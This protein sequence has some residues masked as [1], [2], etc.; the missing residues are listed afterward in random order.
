MPPDARSRPGTAGTALDDPSRSPILVTGATGFVM[1]NL[2]RHL[3]AHGHTVV[4]ADVVPPD[5]PMTRFVTGLRGAVAFERLDVT[6]RGGVSALVARVRPER[7]VH[8]AALTSIPAETERERFLAT[9][10][11][12]VVGTLNVLDALRQGGTGRVV[13]VSSG[14]VYGSRADVTTP[15]REDDPKRAEGLYGLSKW[16][17]DAFARRFAEINGLDLAVTRLCAPF[18][19]FERDTG[20]RPLLSAIHRWATAAV[21]GDV[22]RVPGPRATP[23]DVGY[24]ED[25]ASGITAVLLASRLPHDAYNV[26]WGRNTT[27]EETVAALERL[28]PG[29]TIAWQPD[30][31]WPWSSSIRGPLSVDRLRA[32]TG[33]APRHDLESGL[34]AYLDWLRVAPVEPLRSSA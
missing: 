30:E 14:S 2:V 18:G 10:D 25:V 8:G 23:R 17:A 16:A 3:A 21:R 31:P 15:I 19:P 22:V 27:S 1:A 11:V 34:R 24:V 32:D 5:E 20:S 28:V 7:A 29:L 26:G 4:A 9:V 12:N 13:V 6:D 33:W